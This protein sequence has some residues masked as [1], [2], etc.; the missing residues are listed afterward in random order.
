ML[1]EGGRIIISSTILN[2]TLMSFL[3]YSSHKID[4]HRHIVRS[5]LAAGAISVSGL[6]QLPVN[7]TNSRTVDDRT[8]HIC[9]HSPNE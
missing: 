6:F 7:N 4:A 5:Y 9:V 3:A 1:N 8:L 2:A